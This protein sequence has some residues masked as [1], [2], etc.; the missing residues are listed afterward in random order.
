MHVFPN[1]ITTKSQESLDVAELLTELPVSF[2]NHRI[3]TQ[4]ILMCPQN[5][6]TPQMY[7]EALT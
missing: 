4:I 5:P 2:V 7:K 6:I 1:Q 3:A